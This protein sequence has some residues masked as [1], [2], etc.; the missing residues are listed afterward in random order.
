MS[1]ER[2]RPAHPYAGVKFDRATLTSKLA[3]RASAVEDAEGDLMAAEERMRGVITEAQRD[4]DAKRA[5][6]SDRQ[7]D[8]G[9]SLKEL[10]LA[11]RAI[12][13]TSG[14][15]L[16]AVD[17]SDPE[18]PYVIK[19]AEDEDLAGTGGVI[20]GTE[21]GTF[22]GEPIHPPEAVVLLVDMDPDRGH[23]NY[24]VGGDYRYAVRADKAEFKTGEIPQE[25][26][27]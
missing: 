24:A 23:L 6:L 27:A 10:G 21:L 5:V 3:L 12:D 1:S 26:Q 18:N 2:D 16:A 4:V 15:A 22:L 11:S 14:R 17:F 9:E 20:T 8:A 19:D 13:F 7:Q 25:G